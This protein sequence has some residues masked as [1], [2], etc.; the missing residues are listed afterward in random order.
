VL[1]RKIL[2]D[3]LIRVWP[4]SGVAL[5]AEAQADGVPC[6]VAGRSCETCEHALETFLVAHPEYAPRQTNDRPA[7]HAEL[8]P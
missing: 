2:W 8:K 6:A 3:E 5:C 7:T 4:T 1:T